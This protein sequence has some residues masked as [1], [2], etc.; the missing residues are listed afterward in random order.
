VTL[1]DRLQT[2]LWDAMRARDEVRRDALRMAI[3]AVRGA[4]KT[5]RRPLADDEV[6]AVLARELKARRE[7]LE[8]FRQGGREDL[9]ERE[10]AAAGV[11]SEFLPRPLS[12]DELGE[13]VRAAIAETGASSPRDLGRVMGVLAPRTRGRAEG[14]VVSEMVARE[15]GRSA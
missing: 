13:L 3:A 2:A 12:E 9:A 15:L 11:I 1:N 5:A 4:Q 8:A 6:V 14:R 10:E 7:S